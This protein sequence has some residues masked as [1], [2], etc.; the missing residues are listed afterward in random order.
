MSQVVILRNS[1]ERSPSDLEP[2][3]PAERAT[4]PQT[5]LDVTILWDMFTSNMINMTGFS[6]NDNTR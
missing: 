3:I 6:V 4:E 1:W 5:V 2:G